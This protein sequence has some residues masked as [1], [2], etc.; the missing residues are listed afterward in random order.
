MPLLE[1]VESADR[2]QQI[3]GIE[4]T[5]RTARHA[6]PSPEGFLSA[7]HRQALRAVA[8][9]APR[10]A[11]GETEARIGPALTC[12]KPQTAVAMNFSDDPMMGLSCDRF[13]GPATARLQTL[14]LRATMLR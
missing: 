8:L 13:S 12:P 11:G 4:A 14:A 2:T 7:P 3:H 6:G 10:S 5:P 9:R 1:P